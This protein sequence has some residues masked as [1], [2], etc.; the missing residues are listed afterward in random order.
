MNFSWLTTHWTIIVGVFVAGGAYAYQ[1]VKIESIE[2][3]VAAQTTIIKEQQSISEFAGRLDERLK[4]QEAV[5][6]DLSNKLDFLI[7]IQMMNRRDG[8]GFGESPPFMGV[9]LD[10]PNNE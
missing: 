2:G 9:P 6:R 1:D 4:A 7:K 5:Q 3:V 8:M 10:D